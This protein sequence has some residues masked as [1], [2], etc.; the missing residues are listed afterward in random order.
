MQVKWGYNLPSKIKVFLFSMLT[1]VILSQ[2]TNCDNYE[3]YESGLHFNSGLCFE[4]GTCAEPSSDKLQVSV[5]RDP[6]PVVSKLNGSVV[7]AGECSSGH[8]ERHGIQYSVSASS[9][10]G[11]SGG[12]FVG[13]AIDSCVNG[14][15]VIG[16]NLST[17]GVAVGTI[18][19][20]ELKMFGINNGRQVNSA[21]PPEVISFPR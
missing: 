8:Y 7:I 2:Y 21:R 19:D 10:T 18:V 1:L 4:K 12:G 5:S 16:L 15:F 6:M 17:L 14:K 9:V 20:L 3:D 11:G 13:N